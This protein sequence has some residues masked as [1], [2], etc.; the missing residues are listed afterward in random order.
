MRPGRWRWTLLL[1]LGLLLT[2]AALTAWDY[3]EVK[4]LAGELARIESRGE[5][6]RIERLGAT[7][8]EA[9]SNASRYY[10]AAVALVDGE[11]P[12]GYNELSARMAQAE[13]SNVWPE[14][15][16][17]DMR[18]QVAV[19]EDALRYLDRAASLEFHGFPESSA[20]PSRPSELIELAGVTRVRTLLLTI[21]QKSDDAASSLYA[22]LRLQLVMMAWSFKTEPRRSGAVV[23]RRSNLVTTTLLTR[24]LQSLVS[25]A[26]PSDTS[27]RLLDAGFAALD[28][29]DLLRHDLMWLRATARMS[30]VNADWWPRPFQL[31]RLN[32]DLRAYSDAIDSQSGVGWPAR[33]DN[34][35][36]IGGPL[37][38]ALTAHAALA[39]HELALIR[40][41][42]AVLAME[43]HR[44]ATGGQLTADA[45]VLAA[46]QPPVI[47]PYSGGPLKMAVTAS[48]YVVYSVGAD[49]RDDGGTVEL[50]LPPSGQRPLPRFPP[51]VGLAVNIPSS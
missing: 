41:A 13:M 32:E 47:D 26:S 4:R 42:R 39:A 40:S 38:S 17:A 27:L 25:R 20:Y 45:Q 6:A 35:G 12:S 49:R 3:V 51:D 22:A 19:N 24:Q 5:P 44:R 16:L 48:R 36:Q 11:R 33:L 14:Q 29:D 34:V 28:D 23:A 30:V 43:H 8:R 37:A 1:V 9:E 15:L 46:L 7:T 2:V 31:H 50:P 18:R 21:E 10:R